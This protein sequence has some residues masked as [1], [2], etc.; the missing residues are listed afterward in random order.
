MPPTQQLR[1]DIGFAGLQFPGYETLFGNDAGIR[2][3]RGPDYC[4]VQASEALQWSAQVW[5]LAA[6]IGGL[7]VRTRVDLWTSCLPAQDVADTFRGG[8]PLVIHTRHDPKLVAALRRMHRLSKAQGSVMG[9]PREWR[10]RHVQ[11]LLKWCV[12][13]ID[14]AVAIFVDLDTELMPGGLPPNAPAYSESDAAIARE[15]LEMLRCANGSTWAMLSLPDHSAPVNTAFL[16]VK[17]SRALYSEGLAAL[18]KAG[19]PGG[20][21]RTH[22]WFL[23][24]PPS[25]AVPAGDSSVRRGSEMRSR[26]DWGFVCAALDQGFF[27]YLL[28]IRHAIG[29][30]LDSTCP[31][32]ESPPRLRARLRH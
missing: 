10:E 7:G 4:A 1:A 25:V 2:Q 8:P 20:F 21:N 14:A 6:T 5:R 24:G 16:V 30:D 23:V 12:M 32:P 29:S 22:G 11:L 13:S 15:W 19:A 31:L 27:F 28:R 18:H 17:P 3:A 26:D 9:I